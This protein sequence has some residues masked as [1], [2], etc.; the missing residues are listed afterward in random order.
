[1]STAT[2]T[3]GERPSV[4]AGLLRRSMG[5]AGHTAV[6]WSMATG[7]LVGGAAVAVLTL[8]GMLSTFGL[9]EVSSA[10]FLVGSGFG[11]I[12]GS[13]LGYLGR[14]E[15]RMPGEALG[16]LFRGFL[17]TIPGLGAAW[18]VSAWMSQTAV[19]WASPSA[20]PKAAV[21][22][23]WVAGTL[24]CLWA[25]RWG[26]RSLW[27]AYARWEDPV[28]GTL[29]VAATFVALLVIFLGDRPEIWGTRIRVGPVGALVLAGGVTVWLSGPGVSLP[30]YLSRRL[31]APRL[32]SPPLPGPG[33]WVQGVG[34]G[35]LGGLVLAGLT[36]WLAPS[37]ATAP[38]IDPTLSGSSLLAMSMARALANEV[39]F[40]MFVLFG[41]F[42]L[43]RRWH[44]V[45]PEES[46][47]VAVLGAAVIQLLAYG[48][49]LLDQG[50]VS[51][52]ALFTQAFWLFLVPGVGLGALFVARG[53]PAAVAA[54][55]AFHVVLGWTVGGV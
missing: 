15:Q 33:G 54:S 37:L 7:V 40:R 9:F 43:L 38:G 31:P 55:F 52:S 10:L 53:L 19:A 23:A 21:A 3:P 6:S 41:A 45:H 27:R 12:H 49:A 35:L 28:G 34:A 20:L 25:A 8:R 32:A 50:L 30:L 13:V 29:L 48:P 51:L 26:V 16:D 18:I 2:S 24:I 47:V 39:V 22:I 1:M 42:W 5:S 14:E 11:F 46:A 36:R 4:L 44:P 17:Y